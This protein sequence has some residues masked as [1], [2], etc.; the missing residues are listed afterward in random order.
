TH[1][2]PGIGDD[3]I[4][5][6]DRFRGVGGQVN[7]AAFLLRPGDQPPRRIEFLWAS[8]A[9]CK[10]KADSRVNPACCDIVGVAAPSHNLAG[11]RPFLFLQSH[12]VGHELTW[13][14]R[15]SQ[16]IDDRDGRV[17]H[18]LFQLSRRSGA[19]H[20]RIDIARQYARRI[21]DGFA[22]PQLSIYGVEKDRVTAE[23]ARSHFE[24]YAG[25]RRGLFKNHRQ[26]L[27]GERPVAPAVFVG[28]A[29]V[30][31]AAQ[32][33]VVELVEV[34]KM[35]QRL[36]RRSMAAD[37]R[38]FAGDAPHDG[39]SSAT[40]CITPSASSISR[41]PTISGGRM[42]R[43]FSPA[44]RHNRPFWRS[45]APKAAAGTTHRMPSSKHEPRSSAKSR[46]WDRT[47]ASN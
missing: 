1:R 34:E 47:R 19:N 6:G 24:G 14:R 21:G 43:T 2:D 9:Q 5:T 28:D 4:G 35:A 15:I 7:L 33:S 31:N 41:S 32:R 11:Q 38:R 26:G 20:D 37:Q 18:E 46:G 22:A 40:L 8:E 13:M 27:A 17:L 10:A 45:L 30:E 25:T 3:A 39:H 29:K 42:R 36:R 12:H 44:V 16:P 23:L